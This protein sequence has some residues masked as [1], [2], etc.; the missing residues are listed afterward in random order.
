MVGPL[1]P[2]SPAGESKQ[3]GMNNRPL[4]QQSAELYTVG[5]DETGFLCVNK[6]S[7]IGAVA[8]FPVG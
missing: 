2:S 1:P 6:P 3:W 4:C 5:W 7:H 8:S